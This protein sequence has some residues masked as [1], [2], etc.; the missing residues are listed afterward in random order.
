MDK[1]S[2]ILPSNARVKT[3]DLSDSHPVR[4]GTPAFGRRVGAN[5]LRD[6]ITLSEEALRQSSLERAK[7]GTLN[8]GKNPREAENVRIADQL[9]NQ[10][11]MKKL[12][13]IQ[14]AKGEALSEEVADLNA[15]VAPQADTGAESS[16]PAPAPAKPLSVYA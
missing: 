11:F 5:R 1:I 3:V 4:P 12:E 7:I 10:F 9:T 14:E 8:E 13:P 16:D 15:Q 6:R 2:S